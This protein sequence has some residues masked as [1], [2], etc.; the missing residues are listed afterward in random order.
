[1]HWWYDASE[2]GS[3]GTCMLQD[4]DTP[5]SG[6]SGT[7]VLQELYTSELGCSGVEMLQGTNSAATY[8][9]YPTSG[10]EQAKQGL[11]QLSTLFSPLLAPGGRR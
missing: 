3:Y 9:S 11:K 8:G 4:R 1:M 10:L 5:G 2:L 6:C 7:A